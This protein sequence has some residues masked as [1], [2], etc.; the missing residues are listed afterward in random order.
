MDMPNGG[1]FIS[2]GVYKTI[3]KLKETY[4]TAE[5]KPMT[6]GVEIQA[7]FEGDGNQTHFTFN[8]VHPT[9]A[10]KK[11]QEEMGFFKGWSS[12]FDR[13]TEYLQSKGK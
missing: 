10:Y 5:F 4:S 12:T 11:Q 6:T 13:L 3:V 9:E 2:E 7:L 8:C 1:E